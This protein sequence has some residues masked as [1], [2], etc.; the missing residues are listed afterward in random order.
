MNVVSIDFIPA[1]SVNSA[2]R[3]FKELLKSMVGSYADYHSADGHIPICRFDIPEENLEDL[4]Y[5]LKHSVNYTHA[6]YVYFDKF[7]TLSDGTFAITPT[8]QSKWFFNEC[9][10]AIISSLKHKF[11]LKVLYKEPHL[12]IASKLEQQQLQDAKV[13]LKDVDLD[14]LCDSVCIRI[15][16]A[17]NGQYEIYSKVSFGGQKPEDSGQLTL[18]F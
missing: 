13:N 12:T 11:H 4:I 10:N 16:N 1:D 5:I 14:F 2:V 8:A 3:K 15:L 9:S 7:S 18:A 17:S 6:Q